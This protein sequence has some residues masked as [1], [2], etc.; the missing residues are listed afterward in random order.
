[1]LRAD[2]RV[3]L[4]PRASDDVARPAPCVI[5]GVEPNRNRQRIRWEG[6]RG[7][8][9]RCR[10]WCRAEGEGSRGVHR[11]SFTRHASV[12]V[13]PKRIFSNSTLTA[14]ASRRAQSHTHH[15]PSD[16]SSDHPQRRNTRGGAAPL[17]RHS[18][19]SGC[20][21]TPDPRTTPARP[22]GGYKT[23]GNL[24]SAI[25][26]SSSSL[27]KTLKSRAAAPKPATTYEMRTLFL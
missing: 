3:S 16:H 18:G 20:P 15:R 7:C 1:M 2:A 4:L 8:S 9:R 17:P 12:S 23:S 10:V 26:G 24:T 25:S 11:T 5:S 19:A 22:H 21:R 13:Q 27:G 6:Q 14:V